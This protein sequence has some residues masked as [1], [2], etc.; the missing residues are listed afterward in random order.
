MPWHGQW[1]SALPCFP[2]TFSGPK[3]NSFHPTCSL[4]YGKLPVTVP[5]HGVDNQEETETS[6]N[7]SQS[8]FLLV[9][10]REDAFF[11]VESWVL[12]HHPADD[13]PMVSTLQL[14]WVRWYELLYKDM[15]SFLLAKYL[16]VD[17]VDLMELFHNKKSMSDRAVGC[18]CLWLSTIRL[19]ALHKTI[20]W[21][22]LLICWKVLRLQ[23][24]RLNSF[25]N[26]ACT[27]HLINIRHITVCMHQRK[28][29]SQILL[30][31]V[32]RIWWKSYV[33]L[34]SGCS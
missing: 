12:H 28:N 33:C 30:T 20:T 8:N 9:N 13:I 10:Y 32:K 17:P 11:F 7:E 4:A 18:P 2:L 22:L 19:I 14:P 26:S 31:W 34:E 23:A 27:S 15:F 16:G 3:V 5:K 25:I 6:K 24:H 1:N 29:R 21:A